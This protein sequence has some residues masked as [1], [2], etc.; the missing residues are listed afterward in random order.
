MRMQRSVS[1]FVLLAMV[2]GMALPLGIQSA[3]ADCSPDPAPDGSTVVCDAIDLDGLTAGDMV[4][5]QVT[6]DG[7]VYDTASPTEHVITTEDDATI[8]VEGTVTAA[9]SGDAI[10]TGDDAVIT[11]SADGTV[12]AENADAIDVQDNAYI[13]NNGLVDA[14]VDHAIEA[15]GS[16]EI[17]NNGTLEA[18][19]DVI[20]TGINAQIVNN[21][22]ITS[23]AAD[24]I[25]AVSA[26][27][28]NNGTITTEQGGNAIEIDQSG[29]VVNNGSLEA[30]C[31]GVEVNLST[32]I[33]NQ[34]EITSENCAA[35]EGNTDVVVYN[36]G[37]IST[38]S[39][40]YNAAIDLGDYAVVGNDGEIHSTCKGIKGD[41]WMNVSNNGEITSAEC[42]GV[43][44]TFG[45]VNNTGQI[46]AADDGVDIDQGGVFNYEGGVISG[47]D[48]GVD[49]NGSQNTPTDFDFNGE[50]FVSNRVDSLITG[51][52]GISADH[53]ANVDRQV[54]YNQG[55]IEGTS[56][57]A[58]ALGAG[59]DFFSGSIGTY[60]AEG[61]TYTFESEAIGVVDGGANSDTFEINYHYNGDDAEAAA[62]ADRL[63]SLASSAST[64]NCP[65]TISFS[66]M[67]LS[68]NYTYT[69]FE[70]ITFKKSCWDFGTGS[71]GGGYYAS[72]APVANLPAETTVVTDVAAA[73]VAAPVESAAPA[74]T[75]PVAQVVATEAAPVMAEVV[76]V[77]VE[78]AP[79]Q[80]S[81]APVLAVSASNGFETLSL[82][83]FAVQ[84]NFGW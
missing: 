6:E 71:C 1:V 78:A 28:E 16:V 64:Q 79:V 45:Y 38:A 22:T 65:C 70:K 48:V 37:E 11:V 59:N 19:G 30:N 69:N 52:I 34:G 77:A 15:G 62:E 51:G 4:T 67:G 35:I 9:G 54:I 14:N 49:F 84:I 57:T 31:H 80:S 81:A 73:A 2:I 10:H 83:A 68:F 61:Q 23:T 42:D 76:A 53:A 21:G 24:G 20:V 72:A 13:Q 29:I 82:P 47:G 41:E 26:Y 74:E 18:Q 25:D 27:V 17:E 66:V 60:G 36:A 44:G 7:A 50:N 5:V 33:Q 40:N 56:G 58:V 12:V 63:E 3:Y 55:T 8:S 46:T 75:A 43:A 32:R 39:D